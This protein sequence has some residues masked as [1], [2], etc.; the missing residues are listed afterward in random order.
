MKNGVEL[1][2][3]A[4]KSDDFCL[5]NDINEI[6]REAQ[7]TLTSTMDMDESIPMT[8]E[9]IP[10]QKKG[11]MY[12]VDFT[13]VHMVATDMHADI[14]DILNNII[15]INNADIEKQNQMNQ[16]EDEKITTENLVVTIEAAD[17]FDQLI[18]EA[19]VGGKIGEKAS[20]TLAKATDTIKNMKKVGIKVAKKKKKK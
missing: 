16:T 11:D 18:Q 12:C 6:I 10:I 2:A 1:L 5:N 20:Q 3:E 14:A 13:P 19:R 4:C 9:M 7:E 8:P 17:Y 15:Q